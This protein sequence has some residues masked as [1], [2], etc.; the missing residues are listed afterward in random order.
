MENLLP[1]IH[2]EDI[3]PQRKKDV[4]AVGKRA[5]FETNQNIDD[6]TNLPKA[7]KK[8]KFRMKASKR[9]K[10]FGSL[11]PIK[12]NKRLAEQKVV[13]SESFTGESS[14]FVDYDAH[15]QETKKLEKKE[16]VYSKIQKRFK[17]KEMVSKPPLDH[18]Y[19]SSRVLNVAPTSTE[20]YLSAHRGGIQ[21]HGIP[22][23]CISRPV[24]TTTEISALTMN[25][26]IRNYGLF[27]EYEEKRSEEIN[28]MV[29]SA[30]IQNSSY[31]C[32]SD[33]IGPERI[34]ASSSN[35][36]AT[37][38]EDFSLE[39]KPQLGTVSSLSSQSTDISGSSFSSGA[40]SASTPAPGSVSHST[41]KTNNTMFASRA[42][43][44]L[45]NGVQGLVEGCFAPISTSPTT[46][47]MN[48]NEW[49]AFCQAAKK[50]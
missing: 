27:A 46:K 18:T 14:A 1:F 33:C 7:P 2:G 8:T 16:A 50:S 29:Q 6:G 48:Q 3:Y 26:P 47:S 35:S 40:C 31:T 21:S 37:S 9:K 5:L 22:L 20:R 41:S 34:P 38:V 24:E 17:R 25:S 19:I 36:L 30:S 43:K 39:C 42:A 10:I 28:K 15:A 32:R 44:R 49:N 45:M 23:G 12:K 13:M 4:S 11:G